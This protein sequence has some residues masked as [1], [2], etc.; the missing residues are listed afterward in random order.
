MANAPARSHKPIDRPFWQQ[1]L[2][3]WTPVFNAGNAALPFLLAGF[4]FVPVGVAIFLTTSRLQ[5]YQFDYTECK[6]VNTNRTCAAVIARE[7]SKSCVC[8]E[9]ITLPEDFRQTVNVYYG[10]T[11]FYQN[12]RFYVQSRDEKQLLGFPYSARFSCKPY[13]VDLKT[14]YTVYPCGSIANSL[15]NDSFKLRYK[16][17]PG[18]YRDVELSSVNISWP[19]DRERK[20]RNPKSKNLTGTIKPPNWPVPVDQ[21]PGGL[22]NEAFIVWMRTA[23]FPSLRKLYGRIASSAEFSRVV[24]RGEYFLEIH[25]RYPVAVFGGTKRLILS[26][27]SWMGSRN[28]FIAIAYVC[29]GCLCVALGL[30][31]IV[32]D[33]RFGSIKFPM[34]EISDFYQNRHVWKGRKPSLLP[35]PQTRSGSAAGRPPSGSSMSPT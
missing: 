7:P 16:M 30:A 20:F 19:S 11:S 10:L 23:S 34:P 27:A 12:F 24:P 22:Q 9:I 35:L 33:R 28:P 1:K 6:Q 31:F 21:I 26:N 18:N 17:G 2:P 3:G 25:Y 15:F 8:Y 5:E 32:I 29:V 13:D 4:I 14:S